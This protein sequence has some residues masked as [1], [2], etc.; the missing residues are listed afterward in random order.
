MK[1]E[2]YTD[3]IQCIVGHPRD[4][5]G[6]RRIVGQVVTIGISDLNYIQEKLPP[7]PTQPKV[8]T[9]QTGVLS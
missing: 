9:R 3:T 5:E 8:S 2:V 7:P 6:Q 1:P 4:I